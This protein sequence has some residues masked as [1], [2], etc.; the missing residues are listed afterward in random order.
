MKSSNEGVLTQ[1]LH[2]IT[3]EEILQSGTHNI[4]K[5]VEQRCLDVNAE[6][7]QMIKN[8]V[9]YTVDDL[10]QENGCMISILLN[11]SFFPTT[12]FS[13]EEVG[14]I[15]CPIIENLVELNMSI[16]NRKGKKSIPLQLKNSLSII[17]LLTNLILRERTPASIIYNYSKILRVIHY[18][19]EC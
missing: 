17:I 9:Q 19:S 15:L 10:I 7:H 5:R 6:L 13:T 4:R 11:R 18:I 1:C 14:N 12:I 16:L 8:N 3:L 2:R